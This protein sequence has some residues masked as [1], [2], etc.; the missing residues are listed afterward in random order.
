MPPRLPPARADAA[1]IAQLALPLLIN[2]LATAGMVTADTVM[3]GWL[4]AR[5]LAAVAVGANYVS[6]FH[7]GALG[8]L[9]ALSPTVAHAYGAGRE[10]EVGSFTRNALWLALAMAALTCTALLFAKPVLLAISIPPD[11]ADLAARYVRAVAFGIPAMF[12]FLAMRFSSEGIGWTRP[13]MYTALLGFTANVAGNYLF[14]Y[15]HFGLPALGAVGCGVG[16][17]L[18]SWTVFAFMWCYMRRHRRYAPFAPLRRFEAPNRA[19]LREILA[20]GLP[21]SGS[22]LAE[23]GLFASAGLMLGAFGSTVLAAHAIAINYGSLMFMIPLSLHSATTIHVGHRL[24]RGDAVAGRRAGWV[25]MALCVAIMVASALVLLGVRRYVAGAYTGDAQV[26]A[27]ATHLLAFVAA[28]QVADGLQVG[29][30]GALRGFKDARVPMVLSVVAYWLVGFPLA[31][32]F[33]VVLGLGAGAVWT[34]LIAGLFVAAALLSWRYAFISRR[35]VAV[36]GNS[37]RK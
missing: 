12:A 7:L 19:R 37:S 13:V 21:I 35:A 30:A 24:G 20:L 31:Y 22:V 36:Q 23:G 15:G 18:A 14:M 9:M 29:A 34:G 16:T 17:A 10:G 25:G 28:F 4:G 6:F 5:D 11:V 1:A 33:G 27:L 3:A 26:L 2:N 8:L 32:G